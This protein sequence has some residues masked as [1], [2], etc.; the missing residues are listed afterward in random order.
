MKK[1]AFCSLLLLLFSAVC[2][3]KASAA[4]ISSRDIMNKGLIIS[5][6]ANQGWQSTNIHFQK[7]D[8]LVIQYD[9]GCWNSGK[10]KCHGPEGPSSNVANG[11]GCYPLHTHAESTLVG[12]IGNGPVFYV[13]RQIAKKLDTGG[14]L[15]LVMN[16]DLNG[17]HGRGLG[18]NSGAIVVTIRSPHN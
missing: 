17:C 2:N 11:H 4:S 6:S 3:D 9:S 16:D 1:L 8:M 5:V 14:E 18:D 10:D 15:S 12:K 13:G 7:G